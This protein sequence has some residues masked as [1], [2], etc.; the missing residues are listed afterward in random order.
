MT[1]LI[2]GENRSYIDLIL[3]HNAQD[4]EVGR[5]HYDVETRQ[6]VQFL[7]ENEIGEPGRGLEQYKAHLEKLRM[8]G[9]IKGPTANK[10]LAAAKKRIQELIKELENVEGYRVQDLRAIEKRMQEVKG[11]KKTKVG[12]SPDDILTREEMAQAV[13]G[14][15]DPTISLMI[16][17]LANTGIRISEMLNIP[18]AN[19]KENG[20]V[21]IHINGKGN[22]DRD[23][24]IPKSLYTRIRDH[25]QGEKYL[26]EHSGKTYSR[27]SITQRIKNW[28]EKTTGKAV[29][30]HGMRHSYATHLLKVEKYDLKRVSLMLGHE[31]VQITADIYYNISISNEDWQGGFLD[32][33]K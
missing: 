21:K 19:V 11:F 27:N 6:F 1:D 3:E 9:T 7:Q 30:A 26:F 24:Q 20:I 32:I 15:Q 29:S 10:R 33:S 8:D 28:T 5:K 18:L 17:T 16:E 4:L 25:F 23:V 13:R 12:I 31:S 2:R 14:T 22:K